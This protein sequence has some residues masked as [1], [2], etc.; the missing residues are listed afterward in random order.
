ML[1]KAA[2]GRRQII[3]RSIIITLPWY[4]EFLITVSERLKSLEIRVF[5]ITC[6]QNINKRGST[7]TFP[8]ISF[9]GRGDCHIVDTHTEHSL[10]AA[11][12]HGSYVILEGFKKITLPSISTLS[13]SCCLLVPNHISGWGN[14]IEIHFDFGGPNLNLHLQECR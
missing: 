9:H 4:K 7:N 6:S 3:M 8:K 11:L 10:S 14:D 13:T 5:E 1:V 2:P 12:H